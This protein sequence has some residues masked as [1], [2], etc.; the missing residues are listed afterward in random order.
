[1]TIENIECDKNG[2]VINIEEYWD[3]NR[4][5]ITN[6]GIISAVIKAD[7]EVIE[8]PSPTNIPTHT[9][10]TV[11]GSRLTPIY[12]VVA[13]SAVRAFS[14]YKPALIMIGVK[15]MDRDSILP[16]LQSIKEKVETMK[17]RE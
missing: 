8:R 17:K 9:Y 6:S 14:P 15:S 16:H 10:L 1:M 5:L 11:M 7:C 3:M 13:R 4:I 2:V 12:D